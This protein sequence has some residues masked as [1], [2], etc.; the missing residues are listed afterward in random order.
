MEPQNN[1][2]QDR[3]QRPHK[4]DRTKGQSWK[5]KSVFAEGPIQSEKWKMKRVFAEG[6]IQIEKWKLKSEKKV[7]ENPLE[8]I[9]TW[10]LSLRILMHK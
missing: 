8:D 7:S 4:V 3:L 9:L 6:A 10:N 5:L 2:S 1:S